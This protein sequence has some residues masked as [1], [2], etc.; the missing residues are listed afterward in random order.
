MF[1]KYHKLVSGVY[2]PWETLIVYLQTS[3]PQVRQLLKPLA[4]IGQVT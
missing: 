1:K 3:C 4:N 2:I